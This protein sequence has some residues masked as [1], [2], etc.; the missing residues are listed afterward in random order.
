MHGFPAPHLPATLRPGTSAVFTCTSL[1]KAASRSTTFLSRP[2]PIARWDHERKHRAAGGDCGIGERESTCIRF[3]TTPAPSL[4]Q[5]Y[6]SHA[7]PLRLPGVRRREPIRRPFAPAEA[8]DGQTEGPYIR[9]DGLISHTR[10]VVWYIQC[11]QSCDEGRF[12]SGNGRARLSGQ[13]S[14]EEGGRVAHLATR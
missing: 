10:R 13:E 6:D 14:G 9:R 12:W 4:R 1:A 5:D 7:H 8:E 3:V 2:V 11:F